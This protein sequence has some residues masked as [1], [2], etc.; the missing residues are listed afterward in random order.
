MAVRIVACDA[1]AQPD[2]ALDSQIVAQA[3]LD[4]RPGHSRV[5]RLH[6]AQ[7]AL[8]GGQQQSRAV[9]IDAAAFQH[10]LRRPGLHQQAALP[11]NVRD[12]VVQRHGRV[13]RPAVEPPFG[14]PPLRRCGCCTKSGQ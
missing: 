3:A 14:E 2:H 8:F 5:A 7:Q 1:V 12:R 9:D 6:V 11:R 4:L 10:H 13:F